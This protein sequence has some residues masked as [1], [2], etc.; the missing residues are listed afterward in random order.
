MGQAVLSEVV[1]HYADGVTGNSL[2]LV[3]DHYVIRQPPG[4]K[5]NRVNIPD[6]AHGDW[7]LVLVAS[8]LAR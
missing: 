6:P 2:A 1:I 5:G 4:S 3:A 7:S 8:V